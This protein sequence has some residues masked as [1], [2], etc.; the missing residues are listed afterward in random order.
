L[1]QL[2]ANN[3]G[4]RDYVLGRKENYHRQIA[5]NHMRREEEIIGGYIRKHINVEKTA[6]VE[7]ADSFESTKQELFC[8]K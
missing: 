5:E 8:G 7:F 1:Q 3:I 4:L 2:K 6:K